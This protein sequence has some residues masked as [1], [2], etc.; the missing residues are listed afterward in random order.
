VGAGLGTLQ[1][2]P[3]PP[4]PSPLS[5]TLC[6]YGGRG[7]D[8]VLDDVCELD[9][10]MCAT[11]PFTHTLMH[12]HTC[13]HTHTHAHTYTY[14]HIHTHSHTCTHIPHPNTHTYTHM[15]T[16]H[17]NTH[18]RAHTCTHTAPKPCVWILISRPVPEV[19]LGA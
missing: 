3:V 12:T 11:T 16:L 14:T 19:P 4:S 6:L 8:G 18:T 1:G 17:A 13:T 9:L 7:E 5:G 15:H 10:G 2:R